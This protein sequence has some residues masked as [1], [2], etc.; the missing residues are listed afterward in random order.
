[1][2]LE[3]ILT[4]FLITFVATATPGPTV[5]YIASCGL[6]HGTRGYI[7]GSLGVLVADLIYFILTITGINA[8]LLTSYEIFFL[9]K[10]LGTAYLI[11]LGMGLILSAFSH[12]IKAKALP[13]RGK[14]FRRIFMDGFILHSANPKTVLFFSALLP[15]FILPEQPM[16]LQMSVLGAILLFTALSVFFVY[17]AMAARFRI[18]VSRSHWSK[19]LNMTSGFYSLLPV[20]G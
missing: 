5:L 2:S 4:F 10:W 20:S 16:F 9:V 12:S 7:A 15:Q 17:G 6:S 3:S 14:T 19:V 8:I 1:M 13:A 18:H 11:Y